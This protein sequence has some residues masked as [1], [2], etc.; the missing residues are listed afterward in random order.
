[1][2]E[3]G[4]VDVDPDAMQNGEL[5]LKSALTATAVAHDGIHVQGNNAVG[6]Q[7][8]D[9]VSHLTYTPDLRLASLVTDFRGGCE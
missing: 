7:N 2:N 9:T 4:T 8:Y 5:V 1:M 3:S 6:D